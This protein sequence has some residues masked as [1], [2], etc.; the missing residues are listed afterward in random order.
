MDGTKRKMVLEW[1]KTALIVLLAASALL[2]GRQTELFTDF[3]S[4]IPVFGNVA[5]LVKGTAG[6]GSSNPGGASFIEAARPLTIVITNEQGERYGARNDILARNAVYE[7]TVSIF[8]ETL[9]SA[10]EPMEIGEMEWRTALSGAGVYYEYLLPVKLSILGGWLGIRLPE[11]VGDASVRR[12]CVAFGEDR[13]RV[14]YQDSDS[15][16]FF[17]AITA[18][19]AVKMQEL[20]IYSPN[21]A[22]FAFETGISASESAPYVL[23][24]QGN[25]YSDIRAD[26]AGNM[27]M[28]LG[29]TQ[30]AM[31]H[32]NE[33]FTP[34]Y[35]G[36]G[37]LGRLGTQFNIRVDEFDR[38]VYR[39]TDSSPAD[40]APPAS[41]ENEMIE[42]ARV[43]VAGTLGAI[44][45]GAEVFYE[46]LEYG[47]SGSCSVYFGYYIAGGR[48]HLYEDGYAARI[49]FSGGIVSEA[50]LKYRSYAL[51]GEYTKLPPERQ[52]LVAAGGEFT[53][54][55]YD[56]GAERM[57]PAWVRYG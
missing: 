13:S 57:Q 44:E 46:T 2:L 37:A 8:G 29:I 30:D 39:N 35:P 43:I 51:T 27:E 31:G 22:Q 47:A 3:F 6:T 48:I 16:R 15:D 20:D 24:L 52:A 36:D 18:S 41:T 49:T 45:S 23:I 54:C 25:E 21:G 33:I 12:V 11:T 38:V 55:Y 28:L 9:G 34:Y 56:T 19:S 10:S 26:S 40:N 1:V 5:K 14:Y 32:G 7:R 42:R 53:L 17:V 4:L 50:E